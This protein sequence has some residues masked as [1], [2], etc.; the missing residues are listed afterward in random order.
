MASAQDSIE[1]LI[2]HTA[3]MNLNQTVSIEAKHFQ[4]VNEACQYVGWLIS[5]HI[6]AEEEQT[7][8]LNLVHGIH[9]AKQTDKDKLN[10][11]IRVRQYVMDVRWRSVQND[12]RAD[13]ASDNVAVEDPNRDLDAVMDKMRLL[14]VTHQATQVHGF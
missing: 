1:A 7:H 5:Q 6:S 13:Y 10:T 11:L 14:N 9:D 4:S 8:Y 12:Y 2:A 3:S